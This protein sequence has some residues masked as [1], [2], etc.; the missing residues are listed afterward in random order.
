MFWSLKNGSSIKLKE[1]LISVWTSKKQI[2]TPAKLN[3]KRQFVQNLWTLTPTSFVLSLSYVTVENPATLSLHDVDRASTAQW[4]RRDSC[5][6]YRTLSVSATATRWP[7]STS[8]S[9][10]AQLLV[11]TASL[12]SRLEGTLKLVRVYFY[13]FVLFC[14]NF[15]YDCRYFAR[16]GFLPDE[17]RVAFLG[18]SQLQQSRT[19]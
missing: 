18:K 11:W 10:E 14:I 3:T 9:P 8:S 5:V 7:S 6:C 13:F 16:M 12:P 17:T 19:T 4:D 1:G 2:N 15:F